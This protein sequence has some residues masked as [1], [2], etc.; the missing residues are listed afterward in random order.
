[1]SP[2]EVPFYFTFMIKNQGAASHLRF[3]ALIH[4]CMFQSPSLTET[5]LNSLKALVF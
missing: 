5:Q 2:T 3:P 1:M 4:I